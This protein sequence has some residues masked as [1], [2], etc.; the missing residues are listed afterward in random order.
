M[1][2]WCAPT[3]RGCCP[4]R[5]PSGRRFGGLPP[6]LASCPPGPV[7][8]PFLLRPSRCNSPAPPPRL[9]RS[10]GLLL[11]PPSVYTEAP[12]LPSIAVKTV[13]GGLLHRVFV[14]KTASCARPVPDTG[15]EFD[16]RVGRGK[17]ESFLYRRFL[18]SRLNAPRS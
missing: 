15:G 5:C 3:G 12:C 9:R 16:S 1:P 11:L 4:T 6:L 7:T 13:E 17:F 18:I 8:P 2:T 10:L 14:W